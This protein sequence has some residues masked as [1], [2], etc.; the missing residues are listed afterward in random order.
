[1]ADVY[2]PICGKLNPEELETCQFCNARLK[3]P[4]DFSRNDMASENRT[5]EENF[6]EWLASFQKPEYPDAEQHETPPGNIRENSNKSDSS[7]ELPQSSAPGIPD[8]LASIRAK[9]EPPPGSDG[10]FEAQT[11]DLIPNQSEEPEWLVRLRSRQAEEAK[12]H[13]KTEKEGLQSGF[14][15]FTSADQSSDSTPDW[16]TQL[17]N[18]QLPDNKLSLEPIV[19]NN[20]PVIN[21]DTA[22]NI[23]DWLES[24]PDS[25]MDIPLDEKNIQHDWLTRYRSAQLEQSLTPL[26]PGEENVPSSDE[27]IITANL[28]DWLEK[29]T[30]SDNVTK[31][32]ADQHI[33]EESTESEAL[34]PTELPEWVKAMRPTETLRKD[35]PGE[36]DERIESAGPLAGLPGIVPAEPAVSQYS[37]PSVYKTKLEV[38]EKELARAELLSKLIQQEN[39]TAK[40]APKRLISS[41]QIMRW[42]IAIMLITVVLYSIGMG[43]QFMPVSTAI[44]DETQA[45]YNAIDRLTS[46]SVI[47]IAYDYEPAYTGEVETASMAAITHILTKGAGIVTL[48]TN[49][50]GA[51]L[52]RHSL[53]RAL[54]LSKHPVSDFFHGEKYADLGYLA[55]GPIALLGFAQNPKNAIPY[56][57]DLNSPWVRPPLNGID[58]LSDFS[59]ILVLT[60][61]TDTAMSWIE[62]V[63]TKLKNVPLAMIVSAQTTPMLKP[64][65][66]SKQID[67][68]VSGITGGIAYEKAR[69]AAGIGQYYW[70]AFSNGLFL[71]VIL[72]LA[73]GVYYSASYLLTDLK[74]KRA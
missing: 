65:L 57:I 16:L 68:L 22:Q 59:L 45:V 10:V 61:N 12:T 19:S 34:T 42:L 20:E 31:N 63:K 40:I 1:M 33:E 6:P 37:K 71:V 5:G 38:T 50:T 66:D 58:S 72:I 32:Q 43:I 69:N 48:S 24:M 54:L 3:L 73:G 60:D 2:C 70:N 23:P 21:A 41:R 49:P 74:R 53:D 27:P 56:D 15:K 26:L 28:P 51:A 30:P 18:G 11:P 44:P 17:A 29:L 13:E 55:G 9:I 4:Q 47:L 52:A 39:Q 46:D 14:E 67:G 35:K 7:F 62:Q 64:Y 25:G 36:V 8:W